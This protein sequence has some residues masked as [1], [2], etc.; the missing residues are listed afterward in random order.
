MCVYTHV[1]VCVCKHIH[2]CCVHNCICDNKSLGHRHT[3]IKVRMNVYHAVLKRVN[4]DYHD[5]PLSS[6]NCV[7]GVHIR[8][9]V[10]LL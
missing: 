6:K 1:H 2:M 3:Y 10:I 7:N 9:Y 5:I 8:M 4:K